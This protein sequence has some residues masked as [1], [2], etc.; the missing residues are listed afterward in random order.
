V[1]CQSL[2]RKMGC[3]RHES[4]NISSPLFA[5]L[6]SDKVNY[7]AKRRRVGTFGGGSLTLRAITSRVVKGGVGE[8]APGRARPPWGSRLCCTYSFSAAVTV[9]GNG[10]K[11]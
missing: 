11:L 7:T 9:L 3:L 5:D 2:P 6:F 1:Q 4:G 8:K 10:G